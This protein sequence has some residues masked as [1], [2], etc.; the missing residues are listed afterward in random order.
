[1]S[2]AE[3][4]F[5]DGTIMNVNPSNHLRG[6]V[7]NGKR[8]IQYRLFINQHE[9]F[10]TDFKRWIN[11]LN[12]CLKIMKMKNCSESKINKK[13]PLGIIP[14]NLWLE[15]R[16]QELTKAIIRYVEEKVIMPAEWVDEY[17]SI[18]EELYPDV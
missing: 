5:E 18:L 8:P 7:K 14:R 9:S 13:Y 16:L 15:E 12:G 1:M 3:L 10:D 2:G 4:V 11:N 6:I 17:R